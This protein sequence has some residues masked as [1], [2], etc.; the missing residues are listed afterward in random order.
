MEREAIDVTAIATDQ[1]AHWDG[2]QLAY[3]TRGDTGSPVLLIMGFGMP[4]RAWVHQVPALAEHHRVAWYDQRGSGAT[5]AT[6]TASA[7]MATLAD[8]ARRLLDHLGWE[9]AHI[10]G[11]SMGGMVAQELA[12]R[13]RARLLSLT[14][15]ATHA[16]GALAR[17]PTIVGSWR[18]LQTNLAPRERRLQA[19]ERLLFPAA[20]LARCDRAW[21]TAVLKADFGSPPSSKERR[22]Q[23][24]AIARHDTRTR[25]GAL[26]GLRT[27]VVKPSLD[28][29]VRPS[30][31]DR[32]VRLIPGARL[33]AF[34][35]AGHGVIRQCYRQLNP[36]LRSHFAAA[37]AAH[38]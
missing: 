27:L 34:P 35:D 6:M 26:A 3:G 28:L 2:L 20:F 14:L 1:R 29:L 15:I 36:A 37:D 11:V 12:L 8:D 38:V 7:S 32:L 19:V 30:E 33:L 18:F 5:R 9:R 13:A 25:L 17:L 21:L 24:A 22:W 23:L 10:V 16:G 4:G 31:S